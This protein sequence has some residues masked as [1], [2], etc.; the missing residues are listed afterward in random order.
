MS[1]TP[2]NAR[3]IDEN[4]AAIDHLKEWKT[5]MSGDVRVM[6]ESFDNLKLIVATGF[7]KLEDVQ[8]ARD[9]ALSEERHAERL[10]E[11]DERKA[12]REDDRWYWGK[13][14]GIVGSLIAAGGGGAAWWA[15]SA[16]DAAEPAPVVEVTLPVEA[17]PGG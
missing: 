8:A 10:A 1:S 13:V 9:K 17:S 3:R 2:E 16:P 15:S 5:T 14:F 6:T 4:R 12:K 7:T 11:S